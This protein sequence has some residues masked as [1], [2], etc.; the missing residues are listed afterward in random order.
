MQTYIEKMVNVSEKLGWTVDIGDN[1]FIFSKSSPQEQ[2]FNV[3]VWAY[4]S[5]E[6]IIKEF[7]SRCNNFDCS[8]ETY[9]L[10]DNSGHGKG[11]LYNMRVLYNDIESCLKMME[12]LRDKLSEIK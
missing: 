10:L 12:D 5:L 2:E 1:E 6:E 4:D 3:T 9:N 11:R 8:E 7:E